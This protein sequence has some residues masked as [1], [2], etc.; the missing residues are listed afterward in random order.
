MISCDQR[1]SAS[2][3]FGVAALAYFLP[4][5]SIYPRCH[6]KWFT[7]CFAR[8]AL[9]ATSKGNDQRPSPRNR[10]TSSSTW[11]VNYL[12]CVAILINVCRWDAG[13]LARKHIVRNHAMRT[14]VTTTEPKTRKRPRKAK[15]TKRDPANDP[16][17]PQGSDQKE[18]MRVAWKRP[19]TREPQISQK[20][21]HR[22]SLTPRAT[23]KKGPRGNEKGA[24]G[25]PSGAT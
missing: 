2:G 4:S 3:C 19:P 25:P 15:V 10:R 8:S 13:P 11:T 5:F 17:E 20:G 16:R 18:A 23:Q 24:Q 14:Q 6:R 1:E 9:W 21:I 12:K 22:Q 7:I